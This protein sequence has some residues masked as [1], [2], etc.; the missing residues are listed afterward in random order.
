M[1]VYNHDWYIKK[2][3]DSLIAQSYQNW[4]LVIIDDGSTDNTAKVI[5]SYKD[6]RIRYNYQENQGVKH[7]ADTINKGVRMTKGE[8]ITMLPSD[9][10][11]PPDRFEKQIP[12]F[13]DPNVVLCFGSVLLI[14]EE[15][16]LVGIGTAPPKKTNLDNKPIGSILHELLLHNFMIQTG[17]LIRKTTLE[18]IGLYI[19]PPGLLAEDYP[20]HL[21]LALEGEFRYLDLVLG[22][23]RLHGTQMTKI[24]YLKMVQTDLDYV[25]KFFKQLSP[26]MKEKSG[27]TEDTLLKARLKLLNHAYFQEGRSK[28]LRKDWQEARANFITALI[29]GGFS[30]KLKAVGG[31]IFSYLHNDME[32]IAKI[33][34]KGK[35]LKNKKQIPFAGPK[36][37]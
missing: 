13:E 16:N 10:I 32:K 4:E 17:V 8:L 15:D 2:S 12:L 11:W 3:M 21:A 24:H 31:I 18:K 34:G 9:D 35:L 33:I 20:T 23:Y 14:D 22:Y 28:L 26:E 29:K 36:V 27:W 37:N 30:V 25:M 7:L 19:Q 5:K 1:P 6:P